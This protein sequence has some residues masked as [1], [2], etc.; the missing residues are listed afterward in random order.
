MPASDLELASPLG[1]IAGNG[2]FPLEFAE[3]A[4]R[5]GLSVIAV[6]HKGE[7]DERLEGMVDACTWLRVGEIGKLL[8]T[9]KK[10]GVRQAAFAGGIRKV[11][12]LGGF[13]PDLRAVALIARTGSVQDDVIL[14]EVA[15][16]IERSGIAI[17]SPSVLLE[18]SVPSAGALTLR[19]LSSEE[20]A[21]A[22][23]GWEAAKGIGALDIG[24]TVVVHQGIVLAV[25]AVE[26]TDAAILRAGELAETASRRKIGKGCVIV[27]LAKPQQDLRFDL[28]AVGVQT[29]DMMERAGATAL[30][31]EA[32]KALI[33]DVEEFIR[34]A[35]QQKLAVVAAIGPEDLR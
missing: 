9:L 30:V 1:L 14:R 26:G 11:K 10:S 22:R 17:F 8:D 3:S 29:L 20:R 23:C 33:L 7:T 6:A 13:K 34:R 16:E 28:P 5:R 15:R 12:L 27:K 18:K 24:Q 31:L 32:G 21:D 35:N 25:E 4:R 19:T 2:V